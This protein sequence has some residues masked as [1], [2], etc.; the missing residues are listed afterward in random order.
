MPTLQVRNLPDHL[1]HRLKSEAEKEH[2]SL[3]Q[4]VVAVL[5]RGLVAG[6]DHRERRRRLLVDIR[7][8]PTVPAIRKM[9]PTWKLI[10]EDRDR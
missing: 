8:G 7:N 4:E 2:R 5:E 10:R 3:T 1:Y 6:I 9:K